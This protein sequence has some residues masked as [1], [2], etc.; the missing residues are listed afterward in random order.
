MSWI[1][2]LSDQ[3][4]QELATQISHGT[5]ESQLSILNALFKEGLGYS[6]FKKLHDRLNA[7]VED[8]K[9]M[10]RVKS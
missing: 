9:F 6:Q 1:P 7:Y 5:E 2:K 4:I 3:E 10:G 8:N